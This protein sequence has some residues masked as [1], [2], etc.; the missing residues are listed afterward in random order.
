MKRKCIYKEIVFDDY[1]ITDGGR[2]YS[3][4]SGVPKLLKQWY[5]TMKDRDYKY[6]MVT[7]CKDG[8]VYNC[9]VSILVANAFLPNIGSYYNE[10][11]HIDTN[12]L[13]NNARNLKW[14]THKSNCNNPNTTQNKIRAFSGKTV[15]TC[16]RKTKKVI[17]IEEGIV[18]DSLTQAS[19]ATGVRQSSIS[20]VCTGRCHT[21]GGFTWKFI[22]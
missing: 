12:P 8:K 21:A 15:G 14:V 4:K 1:Y 16:K 11:D 22:D 6:P 2:V 7:L 9:K 10:V 19:E 13:N 5:A 17:C 20:N 3:V 18:Y